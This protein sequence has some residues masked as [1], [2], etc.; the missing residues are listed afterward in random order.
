MAA[1][2]RSA[3]AL[4]TDLQR[5]FAD[6][7]RQRLT[8]RNAAF[9]TETSS[10][11]DEA[12]I[13]FLL[14]S[15]YPDLRFSVLIVADRFG[16]LANGAGLYRDRDG[17]WLDDP[18]GWLMESMGVMERILSHDLRIRVRKT[19]FGGRTG[20]IWIS[21]GTSSAWSGDS[22]ACQGEGVEYT[23]PLPWFRTRS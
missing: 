3:E 4:L 1:D 19:W 8:A 14:E 11:R 18:G 5:R 21:A 7:V 9:T 6:E 15:N 12:F 23:F 16:L 13:E 22:A 20:A 10:T 17:D 2:N